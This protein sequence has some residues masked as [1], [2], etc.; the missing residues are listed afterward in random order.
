M[1]RES[2][3]RFHRLFVGV[4]T[5][6]TCGA[7]EEIVPIT[8]FSEAEERH[9]RLEFDVIDASGEQ[10]GKIPLSTVLGRLGDLPQPW[11]ESRVCE[12]ASSLSDALDRVVL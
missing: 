7:R 4:R 8:G 12:I 6:L 9:T 1:I 5:E 11:A 3:P 2:F 10:L